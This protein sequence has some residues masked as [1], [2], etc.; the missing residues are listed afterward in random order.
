MKIG[1]GARKTNIGT[2]VRLIDILPT[3]C[4]VPVAV[5]VFFLHGWLIIG[6]VSS[7]IIVF[8]ITALSLLSLIIAVVNPSKQS[9][10][11]LRPI[12]VVNF[13]WLLIGGFL[14]FMFIAFSLPGTLVTPAL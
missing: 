10:H 3:I 8:A 11:N 12:D 4:A 2:L 9:P 5:D 7:L 6:N 13:L 1:V 14:V